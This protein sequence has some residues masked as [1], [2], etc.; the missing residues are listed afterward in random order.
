MDPGQIKQET[1]EFA[2]GPDHQNGG[3]NGEQELKVRFEKILK[4][5]IVNLE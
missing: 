2:P 3:E 5:L 1:G 4:L